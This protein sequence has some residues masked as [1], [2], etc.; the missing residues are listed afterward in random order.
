L[1]ELQDIHSVGQ[2]E[3]VTAGED[4]TALGRAE[5]KNDRVFFAADCVGEDVQSAV[6]TL[7]PGQ[8][9]LLEN[10]RLHAEE[11]KNDPEFAKQLASICDVYV[12]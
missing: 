11:E 3:P 10:L 5:V 4:G 12:E 6:N 8:I 9:L 2:D 1:P 7:L